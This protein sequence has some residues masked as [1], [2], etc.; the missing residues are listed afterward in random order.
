MGLIAAD[1]SEVMLA[2]TRRRFEEEDIPLC[3]L[4]RCDVAQLPIQTDALDGVHAGAALHCWPQLEEGVQEIYR[5]LKPGGKFFAT[6][7]QRGAYGV[8]RDFNSNGGASFR[9]FEQDELKMILEAAG[10]EAVDVELV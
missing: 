8:P 5:S 9:F 1:Y 10:F 7:F 2:E 4:I 3:D 6:T